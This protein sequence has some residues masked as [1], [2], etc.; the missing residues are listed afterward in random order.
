MLDIP[1]RS[2]KHLAA[3]I[4]T[5]KIGCLE[6]LDLYL[7]RVEKYDGALNAVVV[8]DFDRA[9]TGA[10]AAARL[11]PAARRADD[12]QGVLRRGRS[13]DHVGCAGVR[14]ERGNEER[15]RRR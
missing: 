9:R 12:D 2:A 7:T 13:A 14:Q 1:F 6:L 5:K 8:R 11:G 4:K 15:G 10:G 3:A